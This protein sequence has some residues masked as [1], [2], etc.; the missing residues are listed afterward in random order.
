LPFLEQ[1]RGNKKAGDNK[2][3]ADTEVSQMAEVT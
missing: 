3:A 2:K 1:K